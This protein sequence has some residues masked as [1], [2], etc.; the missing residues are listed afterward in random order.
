MKQYTLNIISMLPFH[1][2]LK[3][4]M[5]ICVYRFVH[6][7]AMMV[8]I[9]KRRA[10]HSWYSNH[11][12]REDYH[13]HHQVSYLC[14]THLNSLLQYIPIY[15]PSGIRADYN[16]VIDMYP[17]CLGR[18]NNKFLNFRRTLHLIKKEPEKL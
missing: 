7:A 8:N 14:Y 17:K 18:E 6:N 15:I 3:A 4:I 2:S 16:F 1:D 13:H 9:E 12:N 11:R 10:I 5:S